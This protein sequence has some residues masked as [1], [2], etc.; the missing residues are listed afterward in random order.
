MTMDSTVLTKITKEISDMFPKMSHDNV[1]CVTTYMSKH[2]GEWKED[3]IPEGVRKCLPIAL[4]NKDHTT[5]LLL[6]IIITMFIN[7]FLNV[8]LYLAT[9]IY[10][11]PYKN[12]NV[13][14]TMM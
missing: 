5:Y 12:K 13:D 11:V 9:S 2:P 8:V 6:G 3:D 10:N 1:E 4:V 7:M 14:P